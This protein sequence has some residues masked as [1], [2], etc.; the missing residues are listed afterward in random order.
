MRKS[1]ESSEC[2]AD[3]GLAGAI[4]VPALDCHGGAIACHAFDHGGDLRGRAPLELGI[5]AGRALLHMPVDHDATAAIAG[6]PFRHQVAV[7]RAELLSIGRA[8]RSPISPYCALT[9]CTCLVCYP[10]PRPPHPC[11]LD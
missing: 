3:C 6:V 7:P 4:D 1:M 2:K 11:R 8:C 9:A 10:R 5:N